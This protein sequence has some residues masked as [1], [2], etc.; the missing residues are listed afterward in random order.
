M[1]EAGTKLSDLENG[2]MSDGDLVSGILNDLGAPSGG[3]PI[4]SQQQHQQH[5][6]QQQ[7]Q[8]QQSQQQH[9]RMPMQNSQGLSSMMPRANDPAVPTAHMIGREHPTAAEFDRMMTMGPMPYNVPSANMGMAP[10]SYMG[11]PLIPT[12]H[13]PQQ[14][15]PPSKN[16]HGQWIDEVK[17]PLIVAIILFVMTLPAIHLLASHYAPKLL[18]PGGTFTVVGQVLRAL[19]GGALYWVLQRVIAPLLSI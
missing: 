17:Q 9:Q 10:A 16:W 4:H 8:Y 1:A 2:P 13:P 11:Q 7:Q 18:T 5:Q 15:A 6:Q 12:V 14:M 3:N 19:L